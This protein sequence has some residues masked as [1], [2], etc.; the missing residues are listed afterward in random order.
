MKIL[1]LFFSFFL[2]S[3]KDIY[4]DM[5]Y[6]YEGGEGPK[7]DLLL[8]KNGEARFIGGYKW[9]N[10]AKW[11]LDKSKKNIILFLP[12]GKD[13][14]FETFLSHSKKKAHGN[15]TNPTEVDLV[16]RSVKYKNGNKLNILGYNFTK[17]N[18]E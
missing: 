2:V 17:V 3:C 8:L 12:K 13:T 11:K 7:M 9:L 6:S 18:E 15:W 10:P 5:K 1:I 14:D 16:N 4:A